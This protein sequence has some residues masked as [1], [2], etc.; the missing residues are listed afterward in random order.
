MAKTVSF[1]R[2][3]LRAVLRQV[4]PMVIGLPITC[5]SPNSTTCSALSSGE[6][7]SGLHHSCATVKSSTAS[8]GRRGARHCTSSSC[9]GRKVPLRLRHPA[10]VGVGRSRLGYSGR[11]L[12]GPITVV[13]LPHLPQTHCSGVQTMICSL[14]GRSVVSPCPHGFCAPV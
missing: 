3:I 12:E 1:K 5:R 2:L 6:R 14:L 9:T 4:S 11:G 10:Y 8:G 7:R 13:W